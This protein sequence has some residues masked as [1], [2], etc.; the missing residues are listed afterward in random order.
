MHKRTEIVYSL[1]L[2]PG[3]S[4]PSRCS[5]FLKSYCPRKSGKC[6]RGY[7]T[8]SLAGPEDLFVIDFDGVLADT[9]MEVMS[10]G[11][12][13]ARARWPDLFKGQSDSKML[14]NLSRVRPKLVKGFESAI[15]AR[16]IAED[17]SNVDT[18]LGSEDAWETAIVS[19]CLERWEE[20]AEDLS[21]AFEAWRR[22]RIENDFDAWLE[23]NPLY[24]GIK[25]AMDDCPYPFYIASS[26]A[27]DRLLPL[28][29]TLLCL[30]VE[31][32]S[33]RIHAG[34][35]P[36]NE[37]KN[38]ALLSILSK[39]ICQDPATSLHFVDDRFETLKHISADKSISSRVNLYLAGWGYCT[40]EEQ[41]QA[42][43]MGIR[44]L[45][46]DEFCELLRF[47]IIMQVNDG[48]QET[49][50]ETIANVYKPRE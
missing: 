21:C 19:Q 7:R 11:F 2:A 50:E 17:E 4:R 25:E 16:L 33:P 49:E 48:C 29:N 23:L 38:E 12:E 27:R 43:E 5:S 20:S 42:V 44:V 18:I 1:R 31:E 9:Q 47:G 41:Q 10:A 15:M 24:P 37:M 30:G 3:F 14:S 8:I 13:V 6:F 40:R 22:D 28:V 35:I 45:S 26:K 32:D 34:L 36:P 39:P 46:L